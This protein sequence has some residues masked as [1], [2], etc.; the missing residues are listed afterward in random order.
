MLAAVVVA[1]VLA[2]VWVSAEARR[3]KQFQRFDYSPS[4]ATNDPLAEF[5]YALTGG[6]AAAGRN[7]FFN[8]PEASCGRCHRVGGEGGDN[9]PAL[10]G[11]A[12]RESREFLLES[13][14]LPNAQIAKGYESVGV[15]LQSGMGISG[16]LREETETDLVIHTP[17]DG[18]VTVSKT[19]IL[20]RV[21]GVSPMPADFA[22]L[23][24]KDDLRDLMAFL[25]SLTTNAPAQGP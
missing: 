23:I 14:V 5:R 4:A 13:L 9:G 17:D 19:N 12:S 10:D 22:T 15:A 1:V 18:A 8:K 11:I 3:V 2:I 21:A 6:D 24:S 7:I 16:V 25:A 20:R